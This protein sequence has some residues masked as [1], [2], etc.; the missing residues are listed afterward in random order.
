MKHTLCFKRLAF[1]LILLMSLAPCFGP[2]A[3][4]SSSADAFILI[5]NPDGAILYS[6]Y[7]PS[8]TTPIARIPF[9]S[10]ALRIMTIDWGYCVTFGNYAGYIVEADGLPI[11]SASALY[12]VPFGTDYSYRE[13]SRPS[14]ST[15]SV[16]EFPY[17]PSAC[18]ALED[19]ATRS[20]PNTAY[21]WQ[22]NFPDDLNYTVL[23]QAEGNDIYWGYVEFRQ[24]GVKYRLYTGM[25]R[26]NCRKSVPADPEDY[27]MARITRAHT[28]YLGP[29]YDYA[30]CDFS[31]DAG[32]VKACYQEN[33]WLMFEYTLDDG[34]IQR[35]WAPA[36]YW[37]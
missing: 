27:V 28:P 7:D 16:P 23:Y 22:G 15:S 17:S 32:S 13:T 25:W 12:E 29:G 8:N 9:G 14:S 24:D 36:G 10:A 19:I 3:S 37:K 2:A 11:S 21:T 6:S 33:G 31:V 5:T 35:G 20:G 4:A 26:L 18:T 30:V 1:F 34:V